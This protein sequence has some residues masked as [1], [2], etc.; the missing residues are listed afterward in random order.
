MEFAGLV[1]LAAAAV[2]LFWRLSS[3]ASEGH[4]A[5][6]QVA[7]AETAVLLIPAAFGLFLAWI[8]WGLRCDE[9]CDESYVPSA[10]S[11]EW[12]HTT[13]AWQWSAQFGV[14]L[15]GTAAIVAA[16]V[17]TVRRRHDR[18]PIALATAGI[19]FGAWAVLLAPLGDGLG[20]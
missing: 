16:L 12:W 19:C 1:L 6:R 2:A 4:E 20:I 18:A 3:L 11:G 13:D 17:Y 14:A 8:F 5:A 15:I 10:R 7:I 9:S